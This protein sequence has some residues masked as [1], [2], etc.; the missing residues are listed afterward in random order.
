MNSLENINRNIMRCLIEKKQIEAMLSK[1]ESILNEIYTFNLLNTET[2][3]KIIKKTDK[4]EH[5]NFH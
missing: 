3:R 4:L 5:Q 2:C 1:F